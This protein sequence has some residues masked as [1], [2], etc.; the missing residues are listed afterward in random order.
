MEST[1][2]QHFNEVIA[3]IRV[4]DPDV[5]DVIATCFS[6]IR[7]LINQKL[8]VMEALQQAQAQVQVQPLLQLQDLQEEPREQPVSNTNDDGWIQIVHRESEED[9][10]LPFTTPS[11]PPVSPGPVSP[12]SDDYDEWLSPRS[13]RM[14]ATTRR[15]QIVVSKAKCAERCPTQCAVCFEIPLYKNA[16]RTQCNHYYCKKCLDLW[17]REENGSATET[18]C[19]VCRTSVTTIAIYRP[20]KVKTDK[21][22]VRGH[23]QG[24]G[25][26]LN[27][28]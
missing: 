13:K 3:L 8:L 25:Q 5:C 4:L 27:I 10:P 19:P 1:Y 15:I 11:V 21:R 24:Q 18:K 22:L 2:R 16:A 12:V 9:L 26:P 28:F 14:G 20:R 23:Q 7:A 6:K 17:M